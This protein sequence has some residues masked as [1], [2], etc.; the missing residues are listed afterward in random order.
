M[1]LET[2][3]L[4][5]CAVLAV[6]PVL[7]SCSA[8][9]AAVPVP[10]PSVSPLESVPGSPAPSP[11]FADGPWVQ[12]FVSAGDGMV[13]WGDDPSPHII[14]TT[15]GSGS[16]PTTPATLEVVDATTLAVTMA[17]PP[18]VGACTSDLRPAWFAAERPAALDTRSSIRVLVDGTEV[19]VLPPLSS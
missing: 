17:P 18:S 11:G 13:R 9:E 5:V 10:S 1:R 19:G 12:Q 7:A 14:L 4:V 2:R 15:Y 6:A 16:C 8:G 3:V